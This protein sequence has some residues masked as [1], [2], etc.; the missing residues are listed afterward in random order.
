MRRNNLTVIYLCAAVDDATKKERNIHF[1]S[2]AA[3][4]KVFGLAKALQTQGVDV[5]ILSLGRGRQTGD[6]KKFS[7]TAR[8]VSDIPILYAAFWHYPWLT[9][10]VGALS[11][12]MLLIGLYRNRSGRMVVIAYNRIWHYLPALIFSAIFRI[13]CYLDLEDGTIESNK[14]I[15]RIVNF[16]SRKLFEML[17][18]K[19][20]LIAAKSLA[21]Q[22]QNTRV[23]VCYGCAELIPG[24]LA[25]W[26]AKP[27]NILF[28]GSLL[29]ETGVPLLIDAI[30]LLEKFH[31]E[32]VGQVIIFVTG[33]GKMTE[34][35]ERFSNNKGK[36]WIKYYGSVDRETYLDIL[37]HAH[38][39]LC[40]KLSSSSMGKTTFP[41]KIIE[42]ASHGLLIIST[43]VSDVP[44][45]LD[46][47]S[48]IL[49][50]ADEPLVLVEAIL[51]IIHN[52]REAKILSKQ[53]QYRIQ[54]VCNYAYV[55]QELKIFLSSGFE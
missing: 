23:F 10:I 14:F 37:D 20:A 28:G 1:D 44:V 6:G 30:E 36:N 31:P 38:V 33:Q 18:D 40:L 51:R 16:V 19:G 39:G 54:S 4:N 9:H 49:L 27:I 32:L 5:C 42:Y 8:K 26:D 34:Q 46:E 47:H 3:T 17:C 41:S 25:K 13:H 2:P 48:A 45:L 11:M 29:P 43:K 35:L 50:S 52:C 21:D 7:T 12:L 24:T 55:G 15:T 53:G 22:L